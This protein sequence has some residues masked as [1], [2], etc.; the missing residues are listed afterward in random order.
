MMSIKPQFADAFLRGDKT[1]EFR[2]RF[3]RRHIGATVLFYVARP[4]GAYAFKGRILNVQAAPKKDLWE[5]YG[6]VGGVEKEFFVSYF[7]CLHTGY[8]IEIGEIEPLAPPVSLHQATAMCPQ[9]RPPQSFKRLHST[10]DLV[11]FTEFCMQR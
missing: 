10:D 4:V 9:L 8:A 3:S 5:S 1:V 6:D 11:K 7:S 2:R